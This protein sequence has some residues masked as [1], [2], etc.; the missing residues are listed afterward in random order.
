[1]IK[2]VTE[3]KYDDQKTVMVRI[4]LYG[5]PNNLLQTIENND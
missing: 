5:L 3:S 4:E 1:M 2:I